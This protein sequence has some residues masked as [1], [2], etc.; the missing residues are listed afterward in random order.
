MTEKVKN[1]LGI[2]LKNMILNEADNNFKSLL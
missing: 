1:K 2:F